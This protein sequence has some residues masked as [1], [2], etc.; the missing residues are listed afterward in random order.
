MIAD[1]PSLLTS[2]TFATSVIVALQNSVDEDGNVVEVD[3]SACIIA[4]DAYWEQQASMDA[5]MLLEVYTA[6]RESKGEG[7]G[8]DF[9][10]T[11]NNFSVYQSLL[12]AG[13]D[14]YS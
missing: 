12:V 3:S 10:F 1:L 2:S 11:M 5:S 9:G 4:S 6:A 8:T 7:E 14:M 13:F